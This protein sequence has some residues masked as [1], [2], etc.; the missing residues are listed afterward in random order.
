MGVLC[1]LTFPDK[2]SVYFLSFMN[3]PSFSSIERINIVTQQSY[4][5]G[6][7]VGGKVSPVEKVFRLGFIYQL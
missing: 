2:E 6:F 3:L 7:G 5:A 4:P 1:V